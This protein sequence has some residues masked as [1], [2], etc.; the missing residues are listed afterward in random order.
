MLM[1]ERV[2]DGSK[3]ECRSVMGRIGFE[4]QANIILW[5]KPADLILVTIAR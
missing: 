3:S 1:A 2:E 5:R 4:A